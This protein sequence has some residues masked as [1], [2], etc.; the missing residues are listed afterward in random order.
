MAYPNYQ[1]PN[2]L[3]FYPSYLQYAYAVGLIEGVSHDIELN[4]SLTNEDI[5]GMAVVD[6]SNITR[7][8]SGADTYFAWKIPNS[9]NFDFGMVLGHNFAGGF[10]YEPHSFSGD[11]EPILDTNISGDTIVNYVSQS[12]PQF[13]GWSAFG[14]SNVPTDSNWIGIDELGFDFTDNPAYIGSV[15]FGKKW[16]APININVGSSISYSYG[17]KAKKTIG[18]KT[19]SQ[20]NYYKPNKWGELDAW[21]LNEQIQYKNVDSRNGI[22]SWS[23]SMSFLQ[24]KD[25]LP[26]NMMT[27]SNAW[28]RDSDSDYFIGADETSLYNSTDGRDFYTSVIKMTMGSHLPVVVNI[29]DSK[30]PDQWAIVRIT[31]YKIKQSNPKFVDISLT[32]EEQV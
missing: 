28:T 11:A 29:S 22:R 8:N 30:N 12:N 5:Y 4:P 17:N 27:N 14:L 24:D 10:N 1:I 3:T 13:N 32:L 7:F 26:Q 16:E 25:V 20:M 9:W 2:K 18:G 21:E 19:L 31:K 23:V 15:L 6:P